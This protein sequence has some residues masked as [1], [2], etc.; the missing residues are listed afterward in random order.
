MNDIPGFLTPGICLFQEE[1]TGHAYPEHFTA[2]DFI[3]TVAVSAEWI[4]EACLCPVDFR[5]VPASLCI[6]VVHITVLTAFATFP[7]AKGKASAVH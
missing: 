4:A 3:A 1:I 7:A 2:L 5:T 6:E